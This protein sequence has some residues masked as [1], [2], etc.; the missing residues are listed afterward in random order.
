MSTTGATAAGG[1]GGVPKPDNTKRE[2]SN[3][4]EGRSS[5]ASP[6]AV[7]S[8]E[9]CQSIG[10]GM[11]IISDMEQTR[12]DGMVFKFELDL[13]YEVRAFRIN[14]SVYVLTYRL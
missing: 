5:A 12:A 13:M 4:R 2:E 3:E 10:K 1:G 7:V 9:V 11:R 6:G 14:Q 8:E